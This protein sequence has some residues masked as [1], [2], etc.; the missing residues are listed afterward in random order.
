L[1]DAL[2]QE[3]LTQ[4]EFEQA[5][6]QLKLQYAQEYAQ[7]AAEFASM[8]S[9]A[10]S[11]LQSAEIAN[12]EAKYDAEIAAAGD[13]KEEVERLENEK[14]KK[15]LDI[16]KKYADVQFAVTAAEIVSNTALAVMQAYA[17]LGPIAGTVAA[18]LMGITG[19]A[20]LVVAN[21][22]R[23]KVKQMSLSGSGSSTTPQTGQIRLKEGFADGGSN[24]D[25]TNGGY[26]GD[27]GRYEV[28]G[29][30]PVH[31]GEYVVAVPELKR[32]DIADKVR[33][34]ERVRRKRTLSN[35]LPAGFADGGANMPES[36][37]DNAMII[38]R[39]MAL[40]LLNVLNDLKDGR[41]KINYGITELEAAQQDRENYES[42][43]D[44]Q[45]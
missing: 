34:I 14:A 36:S 6:L 23:Q 24:T 8:A 12:T 1:K 41:V 26:T 21:A 32:P 7:K 25:Y 38:D 30:L 13:N 3:L 4:E 40:Q 5:K 39:K 29:T 17:Q 9:D 33:S 15:K 20:Q 2:A 44:L 28:A 18:V 37:P 16:E 42:K 31:H 10:I 35:P 27:G 11:A 45:E 22:Q 43:F 19:A